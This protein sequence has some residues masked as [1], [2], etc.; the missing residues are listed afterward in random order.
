M[1]D[2]EIIKAWNE[3]IHLANYVNEDYR[4]CV[5]VSLIEETVKFLD[6]QQAEIGRLSNSAKQWEE[7]A[8]DLL[9]SKEKQQAEIERLNIRLRK[10]QHQFEDLG[11]MYSEIR[12]EAIK[13]FAERLKEKIELNFSIVDVY[14]CINNLAEEMVGED[15]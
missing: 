12:A 14:D 9:I 7:T 13:E 8:K 11:K 6:Q 4:N 5:A 2:K 3:E 10:E 15:K 1:T